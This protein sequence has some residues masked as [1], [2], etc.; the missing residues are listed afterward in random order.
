MEARAKLEAEAII[1]RMF[2]RRAA[3]HARRRAVRLS[4]AGDEERP[5]PNAWRKSTGSE[6]L[7]PDYAGTTA[8]NTTRSCAM[9]LTDRDVNHE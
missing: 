9:K 1:G 5:V 3:A 4:G 8:I 7:Q 2:R 6:P